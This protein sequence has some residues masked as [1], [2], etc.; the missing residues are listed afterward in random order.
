M[1]DAALGVEALSRVWA[2][3]RAMA[4]VGSSNLALIASYFDYAE[5]EAGKRVIGQDERGDYLVVVLQGAVAEERTQP[6]GAR[7]RLGES[8]AGDLLGELSV[9][10]GG[11]RFCTCTA[12]S[13]LTL[14]VLPQSALD[15]LLADEPRL[16]AA[17]MA[18]M[19]RQLSQRLRQ[20]SARLTALLT[21]LPAAPR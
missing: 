17:L 1:H 9:L 12:L 10:D 15:R 7:I 2:Q 6:S 16:G 19:A 3:D 11:T 5:I 4:A 18:W 21:R 8:R 13:P 14:A 20:T